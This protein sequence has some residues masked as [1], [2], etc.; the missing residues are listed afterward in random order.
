MNPFKELEI[1]QCS[2]VFGRNIDGIYTG[3]CPTFPLRVQPSCSTED[4]RHFFIDVLYWLVI[5]LSCA[6]SSEAF[7]LFFRVNHVPGN[8]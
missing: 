4:R 3:L 2:G 1:G 8:S 6:C 5:V 7:F